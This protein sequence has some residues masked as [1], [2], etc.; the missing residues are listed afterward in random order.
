M[1]QPGRHGSHRHRHTLKDRL[2]A[3]DCRLKVFAHVSKDH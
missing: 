1:T 3:Q 2:Q